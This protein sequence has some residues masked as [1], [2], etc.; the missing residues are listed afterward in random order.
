MFNQHVGSR[1]LYTHALMPYRIFGGGYLDEIVR[2]LLPQKSFHFWLS[3]CR[4]ESIHFNNI[5]YSFLNS[6]PKR[7]ILCKV[8]HK[9]H[10]QSCLYPTVGF[11]QGC[12]ET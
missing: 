3:P 9:M 12:S 6:Q 2:I 10:K 8:M 1:V 7:L 4:Q 11:D 5:L